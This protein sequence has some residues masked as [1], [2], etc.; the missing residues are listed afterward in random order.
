MKKI[1][2][3]EKII[4]KKGNLKG[5]FSITDEEV[6]LASRA[7]IETEQLKKHLQV[8]MIFTNEL[9]HSEYIDNSES[10]YLGFLNKLVKL[11]KVINKFEKECKEKLEI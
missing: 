6:D 5:K 10:L 2:V 11:K 3:S 7:L 1:T 8:I 9:Q 4:N